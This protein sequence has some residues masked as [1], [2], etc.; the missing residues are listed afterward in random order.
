[1]KTMPGFAK[2]EEKEG[3]MKNILYWLVNQVYGDRG[4]LVIGKEPISTSK[5]QNVLDLIEGR[6]HV[7]R[8]PRI[9]ERIN[10]PG[11]VSAVK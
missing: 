11:F 5:R 2:I 3:F 7:R 9:K 8:Y 1:M 10:H 4:M 6:K